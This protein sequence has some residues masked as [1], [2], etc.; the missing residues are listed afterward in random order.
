MVVDLSSLLATR[1][2]LFLLLLSRVREEGREGVVDLLQRSRD[3]KAHMKSLVDA[4]GEG[5]PQLIGVGVS[6]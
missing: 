2:I 5:G 4:E 1:W 3:Q 6:L